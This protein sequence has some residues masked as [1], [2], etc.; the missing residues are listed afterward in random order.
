VKS[1]VFINLPSASDR[2]RSVEASFAAAHHDGWSLQRFDAL[3][4]GEVVAVPGTLSPAEKGCF[5]SHRAAIGDHLHDAEHLFVAE[6]DVVFS[7]QTFTV[8][9]HLLERE[10]DVLFTDVALCD[11]S[12]MVQLARLRDGP[13]KPSGYA[14]LNLAGR[15]YFGATAYLIRGSA[16]RELHA[17]LSAA[18]EL[19]Q[20]YDLFLRELGQAGKLKIGACFPFITT[21]AGDADESQIQDGAHAVFD[22]TL[23]AYR[24]L[25]YVERDLEQ[26]RRDSARLKAAYC[27]EVAQ[28]VGIVFATIV[29]P[30]F[31]LD[32]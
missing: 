4:P 19:N 10:W 8:L 25:M 9:D 30:A 13:S 27:D 5:A 23:N 2:R 29:S 28:M 11:L 32:R 22:R 31:P 12:L 17:A 7:P 15:S 24:R 14:V 21:L 20:P 3:G 26:C 18:D 6:D 16:K 1:C